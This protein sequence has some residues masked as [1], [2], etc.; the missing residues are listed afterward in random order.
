MAL[1]GTPRFG[2]SVLVNRDKFYVLGGLTLADMLED[3]LNSFVF[4][5]LHTHHHNQPPTPAHPLQT[6]LV[7]QLFN[8]RMLS[9]FDTNY[10]SIGRIVRTEGVDDEGTTAG[11]VGDHTFMRATTSRENGHRRNSESSTSASSTSSSWTTLFPRHPI[12]ETLTTRII[13]V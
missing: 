7:D 10:P 2:C 13:P 3:R 1:L 4:D 5:D 11:S 12:D 9:S 8:I 6:T